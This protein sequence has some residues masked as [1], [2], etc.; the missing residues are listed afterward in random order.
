MPC[1]SFKT[2]SDFNTHTTSNVPYSYP[3]F[4]S[5][6][7]YQKINNYKRKKQI[8]ISYIKWLI[9]LYIHKKKI[10][11]FI[12]YIKWL[13]ILY[14]HKK[15]NDF[16]IIYIKWRII[17]YIHTKIFFIIYIKWLIIFDYYLQLKSLTHFLIFIILNQILLIFSIKV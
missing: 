13:I 8:L 1:I 3:T 17:L 10:I 11:F 9:I 16:F 7:Y 6:C 5:Y 4:S 15:K 2:K 14:I 12:I